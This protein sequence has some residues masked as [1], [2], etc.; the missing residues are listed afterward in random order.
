M[1]ELAF[2]VYTI[3]HHSTCLDDDDD[4]DDVMRKNVYPFWNQLIVFV[5][6]CA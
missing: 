6:G 3:R 2:F 5:H 1:P 4:D